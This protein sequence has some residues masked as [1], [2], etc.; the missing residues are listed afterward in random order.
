[1]E[2]DIVNILGNAGCATYHDYAN[3]YNREPYEAQGTH[4]WDNNGMASYL[5]IGYSL[6]R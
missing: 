4:V 1:M 5:N 2:N 3:F 6:C